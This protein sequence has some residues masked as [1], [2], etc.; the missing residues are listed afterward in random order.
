MIA[1]TDAG[2]LAQIQQAT[3][4]AQADVSP[5][6][7]DHIREQFPG[8]LGL[9]EARFELGSLLSH[10]PR[11]EPDGGL[12]AGHGR[13]D[14]EKAPARRIRAV[15]GRGRPVLRPF[16][17]DAP[18]GL[19]ALAAGPACRG[20]PGRAGRAGV[21]RRRGR[22]QRTLSRSVTGR[23]IAAWEPAVPPD[24]ARLRRSSRPDPQFR[25]AGGIRQV[26]VKRA[27]PGVGKASGF[28]GN[29]RPGAVT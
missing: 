10:P 22:P 14:V 25:T 3:A 15:G 9:E 17:A 1:I 5:A 16:P 20:Q 13:W 8:L 23:S 2:Y 28:P 4:L 11:L 6:M 26:C 12:T 29:A 7:V 18:A 24:P 27:R 21:Q 19:Q